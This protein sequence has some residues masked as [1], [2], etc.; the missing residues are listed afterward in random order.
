MKKQLCSI[1]L[2]LLS[3]NIFGQVNGELREIEGKKVLTI[4]GTHQERGYAHGYLM[5]NSIEDLFDSYIVGYYFGNSA[6][7]YNTAR[8]FFTTNYTIEPNYQTEANAMIQGMI[9]GGIDLNNQTLGREI[10]AT[11]VLIV[12]ALPD[13][14]QAVEGMPK[15]DLGCSSLS[16]WGS[17]TLQ[18][19]TLTGHLVITRL[20]DWSNHISLYQNHLMIVNRPSETAEQQWISV[21]FAGFIGSLSGI[22]KSGV[23]AFMNVGNESNYQTGTPFYPI[24]LTVRNGIEG[25]DYNQD[26]ENTPA[27][28]IQAV[29]DRN[30]SGASI[31]HVVQD[32]GINSSPQI[33]ECNNINGVAVRNV[34]HNTLVPGENLVVTNHFRILSTPI[35]C[36]RYNGIVD[37]LNYSTEIT[38][39]RSWLILQTAACLFNNLHAI[40]YIGSAHL[41]KWAATTLG[42]PAFSQEP[43]VFN[44]DT[45]FT[46]IEHHTPA[47]PF[48]FTLAQNY[49]N[50]FN[51]T[52]VLSWQLPVGS[53]VILT[54][55]NITGQKIDILVDEKQLAGYH[56]V[57]W[58]AS[59]L[60][61]GI[62]LYHL[63]AGD[64][65][66][67]KK[68][69]L[70]K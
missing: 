20:M 68:L 66:Q 13:L 33:I 39:H 40:Q 17:S 22:N 41:L 5:G 52:T 19:S 16:S 31:I 67:T 26:G 54:I 42:N 51:S 46:C 2:L 24:L 23:A 65:T 18:D 44:F 50:P 62:Y 7:I 48:I 9:D 59:G 63:E 8:N 3:L 60:T 53:P 14:S 27:D 28:I 43:T 45:L 1:F 55:F 56:S 70:L 6:P 58:N 69:I 30:R 21:A 10:D 49:P 29:Q 61:S 57:E 11:D 25:D 47:Q 38:P 32:E 35:S 64:F 36:Y 15:S 37:S 12:T 4:W 34:S